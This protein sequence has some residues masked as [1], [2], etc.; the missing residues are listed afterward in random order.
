MAAIAICPLHV[1]SSL[2]NK[3]T[4]L[5]LLPGGARACATAI[6]FNCFL[7]GRMSQSEHGDHSEDSV[8]VTEDNDSAIGGEEGGSL[9]DRFQLMPGVHA[10][11]S[12]L[13]FGTSLDVDRAVRCTLSA[14]N[15]G[16]EFFFFLVC[17]F[18]FVVSLPLCTCCRDC[19]QSLT[20]TYCLFSCPPPPTPFLLPPSQKAALFDHITACHQTLEEIKLPD[21]QALEQQLAALQQQQ[22]QQHQ[23]QQQQEEEEGQ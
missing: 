7:A 4:L 5:F 8:S 16:K 15:M 9:I 1:H 12:A 10:V 21:A 23:Q 20:A 22:Q 18:V 6:F 13:Q 2:P 19:C 3:L 11:L 17:W 14:T